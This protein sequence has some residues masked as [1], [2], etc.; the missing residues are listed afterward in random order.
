M[1]I[2]SNGIYDEDVKNGSVIF[3]ASGN[4][5]GGTLKVVYYSPT[6]K[7]Y[8]DLGPDFEFTSGPVNK[9]IKG[10]RKYAFELT[11]ATSPDLI[12]DTFEG[13]RK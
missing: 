9:E 2:T 4:F 11:G 3:H 8:V 1:Q 6:T 10:T 13:S 7:G 5:G 12:L